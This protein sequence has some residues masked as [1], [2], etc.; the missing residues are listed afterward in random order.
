[1][2]H[3]TWTKIEEIGSKTLETF[4]GRGADEICTGECA[5]FAKRM[6]AALNE[7]GIDFEIKVTPNFQ[8]MD[9]LKGYDVSE[10]D[11]SDNQ[12]SHCYIV[13]DGIGFDAYDPKGIEEREM[14][15]L[16]IL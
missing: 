8:L 7:A 16:S 2:T 10:S 15:F 3:A 6:A 12:I 14:T 4:G 1:M 9:E 5:V 11:F 13:I